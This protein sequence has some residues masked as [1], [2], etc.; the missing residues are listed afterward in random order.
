MSGFPGALQALRESFTALGE[1]SPVESISLED[2]TNVILKI[3]PSSAGGDSSQPTRL[4]IVVSDPDSYPSCGAL[5]WC[6]DRPDIADALS[7][8]SE[9]F[10]DRAP[11]HT[12]VQKV[13]AGVKGS[14]REQPSLWVGVSA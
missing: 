6:E 9:R 4:S 8:L 2:G 14:W 5:L 7:S 10:L 12:V 1:L 3:K 11:L 13:R